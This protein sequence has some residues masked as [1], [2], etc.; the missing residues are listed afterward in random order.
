ME[1]WKNDND[2]GKV[3]V[4]A[5]KCDQLLL[6]QLQ[7]PHRMAWN[8]TRVSGVRDLGYGMAFYVVLSSLSLISAFVRSIRCIENVPQIITRNEPPTD[9]T[10]SEVRT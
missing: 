4:F 10:V 3:E 2:R 6:R 5:D 8:E 1:N 9:L 7:I